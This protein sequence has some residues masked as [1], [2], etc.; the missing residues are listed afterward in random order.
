V[1]R[2]YASPIAATRHQRLARH[3]LSSRQLINRPAHQGTFAAM[4]LKNRVPLARGSI[5]PNPALTN[6]ITARANCGQGVDCVIN[7]FHPQPIKPNRT[8]CITSAHESGVS[9]GP[10][11][12]TPCP[13]P[14]QFVALAGSVQWPAGLSPAP[15]F[16]PRCGRVSTTEPAWLDGAVDTRWRELVND[17]GTESAARRSG[18][19][20]D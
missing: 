7:H 14:G 10:G 3:Q 5:T 17:P 19:K 15:E 20:P 16:A 12:R 2:V 11:C 13:L 1:R 9:Q 8:P 18:H 6:L 4:R